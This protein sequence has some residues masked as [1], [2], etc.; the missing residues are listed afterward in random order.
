VLSRP[1]SDWAIY[2]PL[3]LIY[4]KFASSY[5]P[6][7]HKN[8]WWLAGLVVVTYLLALFDIMALI[9]FPLAKHLF[10]FF[11]MLV[12]PTI[13]RNWIPAVKS[14]ESIGKRAYGLYFM[15]LIVL[16]LMV[17][18]LMRYFPAVLNV[19]PL[20]LVFLF[21]GALFIPLAVMRGVER[22]KTPPIYRYVFG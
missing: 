7:V 9:R 13:N 11:F 16:D 18:A 6:V 5:L 8:R 21:L 10:P 4:G 20:V 1:L 19:Y 14:I 12:A 2:F 17:V 3:G 22:I 15:N